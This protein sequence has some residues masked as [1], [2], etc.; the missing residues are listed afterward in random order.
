MNYNEEEFLELINRLL[1]RLHQADHDHHGSHKIELVYVAPGGQHVD[2][3]QTQNVYT[4]KQQEPE[5]QKK[6]VTPEQLARAIEQCQKFFWG[7]S[8]YAV[9]FCLLRDEYDM[10][11]NQTQFETMVEQLPYSHPRDYTCPPGTISSAFNRMPI[12]KTHVSRWKA[13]NL[14][15]RVLTLLSELRNGIERQ[16]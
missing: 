16:K 15:P 8:A 5:G 11:D 10:P 6:Q 3:I 9:L 1:E 13:Q 12:Y 14:L 4:F 7:N 2:S